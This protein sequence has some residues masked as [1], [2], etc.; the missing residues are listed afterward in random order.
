MI[1]GKKVLITFT[2]VLVVSCAVVLINTLLFPSRQKDYP[3][4]DL[5]ALSES[6]VRNFQEAIQFKTIS[7]FDSSNLDTGQFLGFH[8][9]L[10]R[11]YPLVH[12][13]FNR[14]IVNKYSLLYT[15]PGKNPAL[16]AIILIAHM[17][18]VPVENE[19]L[20]QWT[21]DPFKGAIVDGFIQGRGAV[22]NKLNLIAILESLE[23][24]LRWG[25]EPDR[26]IYLVF[27]HDEEAGGNNGAKKIA[28]IL[29]HRNIQA[30]LIVD[31]GGYVTSEIVPEMN[32]PI[33]LLGTSE[34]GYLNLKL[35][36]ELD[37][38]HSSMPRAETAIG[39]MAESIN[40]L[41]A[42]EFPGT[43]SPP[44]RDFIEHV[45]PALPFAKKMFFANS[46]LFEKLIIHSYD[47]SPIGNAMVHTLVTPTIIQAGM[48]ENVVP[49]KITVVVNARLLPGDSASD[50]INQIKE[51]IDPR[52]V[53]ETLK[54]P[55][56]SAVTSVESYG[57]KLVERTV[58]GTFP[59]A[60]VS[61][62]LL[63][64]G[65]DSRYFN[66]M[67]ESIVRFSPMIEAKGFHGVNERV[68]VE[69]FR[70]AIGFYQHLIENSNLRP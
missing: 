3:P 46:F 10:M 50:V 68:S 34:K 61:P 36:L 6:S 51:L 37:G 17:D 32:A 59:R 55:E 39:V 13:T 23:K 53:I 47:K 41:Q 2:A 57:Y 4:V 19:T 33:A 11:S 45:G 5:P 28:A 27:G 56:T 69:G 63:I 40:R 35:T 62:F 67:S 15:W 49:G 43:I 66:G 21:S 64:G 38:G 18:V 42:Y 7:F 52:I 30:D 22:D 54:H 8:R 65:T 44:T 14:E 26:P 20:P 12:Q 16:K 29:R 25:F 24:L 58:R 60:L 48:K 9:F 1:S 70:L 31:E